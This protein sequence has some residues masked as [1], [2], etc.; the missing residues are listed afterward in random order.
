MVLLMIRL[1]EVSQTKKNT[2][3]HHLHVESKIWY[4]WTYLQNRNRPMG[5]ENRLMVAKGWGIGMDW[6]F[7]VRRCKLVYTEWINNKVLLY[8]MGNAFNVLRQATMERNIYIYIYICITEPLA[9]DQKLTR[10]KSTRAQSCPTLCTPLAW[11][12]PASLSMEFFRVVISCSRG[13]PQ[14]RDQ[15][16]VSCISCIGRQVLY[17]SATWETQ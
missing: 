17:H 6:A 15:A 2:I 13:S 16:R 8:S 12:P 11:S 5:I 3:W 4:K 10:Y 1:S 9:V 14:P 7:G